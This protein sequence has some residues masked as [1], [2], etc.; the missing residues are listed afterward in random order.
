MRDHFFKIA[1]AKFSAP[2][3]L[4]AAIVALAGCSDNTASL[5]GGATPPPTTNVA[6]TIQLTASLPQILTN[7][8]S[9]TDLKAIVL[10]GTGQS[11]A[12]KVVIFSTNNDPSAY[13][14]GVSAT[15]DANG[16]ATATLN[17]G[18][19]MSN[20]TITVSA[21]ADTAVGTTPVTV[22]GT[23]ISISG[24]TSLSMNA[25]TA[26]TIS[27]K[28]SAGV[29]VPSVQLTVT[30]QN[31]NGIVLANGG[32]TDANGQLVATITAT[33]AT[34][35]DTITVTGAGATQT[36]ALTITATS[37]SFAFTAP[38]TIVPPATTPEILVNTLTAVSVKWLVGGVAQSG[39]LIN[40]YSSRG[41][42]AGGITSATTNAAGVATVTLQS[43]YAGAA[44]LSAYGPGNTPVVSENIVFVTATAST[45]TAQANPG[46]IGINT[47][48]SS[49]NQS[50][51]SVVVR[52]A[53]LNLVKNANVSFNLVADPSG[54]SLS[55]PVAVTDISGTASVNYIAGSSSSGV[56]QVQIVVT[57]DSISGVPITP[58]STSTRL[59]VAGQVYFV[60]LETDNSVLDGGMYYIKRY[61]ALVTDSSGHAVSNTI[62]NFTL[63]PTPPP[64]VSFAKGF[65]TAGTVWTQTVTGTCASEDTNFNAILDTSEDT[66]G[67]GQLDPYGV[68]TVNATAT[69]DANGYAIASLT[70]NKNYAY[71]VQLVLEART[72][73]TGNDPP[74]LVTV[75]FPGAA[76]D[77]ADITIQVPGAVSPF[78]ATSSCANTM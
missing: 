4:V 19:N 43:T 13:F 39:Q 78:G 44:T 50:V 63:R 17:L 54:G 18:F 11:V 74:A 71:W 23:T 45:V 46:T 62:V 16:V 66:N 29:A 42:F 3:L 61:S 6:A 27:V 2:F 10:D 47:S 15:T 76:S 69:T 22:S 67:N 55:A 58:I 38:I 70:Y 7:P 75:L 49:T 51:I 73:V 12:G 25:S 60:R 31:G 28:N 48:G 30:S 14:T 41:T 35:P 57:V 59:T 26:L 34:T 56:N 68:A 8:T 52:D 24:N 32:V 64:A 36:Q 77:Y 9:T 33:S 40:F 53:A 65:F 72:M 1:M 20:R 5:G 21:T 37:S